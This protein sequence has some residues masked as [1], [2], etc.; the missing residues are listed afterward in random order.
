MSYKQVGIM[1]FMSVGILPVSHTLCQNSV[2]GQSDPLAY[3]AYIKRV[4][5]V[6]RKETSSGPVK[7]IKRQTCPHNAE[8]KCTAN[9]SH[10]HPFEIETNEQGN[11]KPI[12]G[13]P[14]RSFRAW[15]TASGPAI[16]LQR[17]KC[18]FD[19]VAS[20]WARL[21]DKL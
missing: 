18:I 9:L 2:L 19:R 13:S 16:P 4:P 3:R 12:C 6:R 11:L 8:Q 1:T 10:G 14:S 21:F 20:K 17:G 5:Q 7:R 15:A